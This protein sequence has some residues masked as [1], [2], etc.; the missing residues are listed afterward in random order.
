M[1]MPVILPVCLGDLREQALALDYR[2][3]ESFG[4]NRTGIIQQQEE[5]LEKPSKML[6]YIWKTYES[7]RIFG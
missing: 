2:F 6:K 3:V 7:I 1:L 5:T 4:Y